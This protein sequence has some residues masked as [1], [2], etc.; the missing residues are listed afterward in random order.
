MFL[1]SVLN[2]F[3]FVGKFIG[4]LAPLLFC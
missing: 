1:G 2:P 4:E 3:I